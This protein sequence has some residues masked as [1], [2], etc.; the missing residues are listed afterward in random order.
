MLCYSNA[1]CVN[2]ISL[3]DSLTL[4]QTRGEWEAGEVVASSSCCLS[5]DPGPA[6]CA[7]NAPGRV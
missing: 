4:G 2:V 7:P 1:V 3:T 6:T 5:L